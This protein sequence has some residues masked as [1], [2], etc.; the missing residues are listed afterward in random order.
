VSIALVTGATGFAGGHLI[1]R[2]GHHTQVVGWY[3][4]AG[5]P[6]R[7]TGPV[8]WRPVDLLDAEGVEAAIADA[9]PDV[10]YHLAGAPQVD[11]SW[12]TV[13]PHLQVNAIGTHHLLEAIRR[14]GR[15][16]RVLIV[17]S[18]QIYQP[19]PD[20]ID[21]E[22]P[23]LPSSPYGL[24]KLAQ[25]ALARRAAL[26]DGLDVAIAR[27]FNHTGPGQSAAFALPSFAKQIARIEAG[28][29][30][31]V[32]RVGNLDAERDVSDVRDVVDAYT[33]IATAA[34]AARP[35]NVCSGAAYRIGDL[36]DRLLSFA[37]TR[38]AVERDP[39]RLRPNDVPRLMGNRER[40]SVELGWRPRIPIDQT[41][42]DTLE[43]WRRNS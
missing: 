34:P 30:S 11:T 29:A 40:V 14:A 13:V 4:P 43:W 42:L 17:T 27:P 2:L 31:P 5:N 28:L 12:T 7:L 6:R 20:A 37:S 33:R 1:D 9:A 38:I 18:A 3:R 41:L 16:C 15:R 10:V 21:E 25:D 35:F 39:S 26:E 8:A 23:L 19:G 36:L 22:A 24:S 32:L